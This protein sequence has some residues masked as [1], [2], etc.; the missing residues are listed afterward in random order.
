MTQRRQEWIDLLIGLNKDGKLSNA[1][2][3]SAMRL[4]VDMWALNP[5]RFDGDV[6]ALSS[7]MGLNRSAF[8]RHI[9]ELLATGVLYRENSHRVVPVF[10]EVVEPVKDSTLSSW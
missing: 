5:P 2:F 4:G 1:A 10:P 9:G 6:Q 7:Y 8:Y 3:I